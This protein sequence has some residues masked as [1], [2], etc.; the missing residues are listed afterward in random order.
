MRY[1]PEVSRKYEC[2]DVKGGHRGFAECW[3]HRYAFWNEEKARIVLDAMEGKW[4]DE[5]TFGSGSRKW[6]KEEIEIFLLRMGD[7]TRR[8]EVFDVEDSPSSASE[9][10]HLS[11]RLKHLDLYKY[12]PLISFFLPHT[13]KGLHLCGL[14]PLP[15]SISDNPLPPHP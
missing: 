9:G 1:Q 6:R 14:C 10:L 11:S 7:R 15:S 13:V 3:V 12:P 2:W 4:L 8:L 5:V